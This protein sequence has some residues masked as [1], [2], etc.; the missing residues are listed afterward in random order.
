MR[1]GDS[2]WKVDDV[3][4]ERLT[5]ALTSPYGLCGECTH[6]DNASIICGILANVTPCYQDEKGCLDGSNDMS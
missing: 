3:S 2:S 4:A 1:V 6:S 5:G